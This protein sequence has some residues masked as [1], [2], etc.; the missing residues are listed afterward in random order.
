MIIRKPFFQPK[1]AAQMPGNL[2]PQAKIIQVAKQMGNATAADQ[3]GTTFQIYDSLPVDGRTEYTFFESAGSKNFP[4]TNM[5]Q[6]NGKL[7]VGETMTILNAQLLFVTFTNPVPP[8]GSVTAIA[9]LTSNLQFQQ[10]ELSF[11]EGEARILR[12]MKLQTW[13]DQYNK[14]A[15]FAGY[16][17][18]HFDTFL[19]IQSLI[20]FQANIRIPAGVTIANTYAQLIFEGVGGILSPKSPK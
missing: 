20:E 10:G 4:L 17:V 7:G 1:G 15:Q 6:Q 3:Q 11:I 16:N 12:R 18:F 5:Q 9:D 14:N 19:T 13:V 2:T 8:L